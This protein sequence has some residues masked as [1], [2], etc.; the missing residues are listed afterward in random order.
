LCRLAVSSFAG[1]TAN[2][3]IDRRSQKLFSCLFL[4]NFRDFLKV[5]LA[6]MATTPAV[7]IARL[8]SPLFLLVAAALMAGLVA[9]VA[10][11]YLQQREATMKA[12]IDA[13]GKRSSTPRV[14][15]AV[16]IKDV[17]AG[18]VLN[19]NNFVARPVEADLVY[20]DSI[21]AADFAS[22][23]G[24]KLAR[25][26]LRGRPVRLTDLTAP[27]IR[28]V[29]SILPVGQRALTIDIDNINSIAQ[30]LRPNH[31][32]DVFLL[33]KTPRSAS[34]DN[35]EE[36][37]SAAEQATLYMQ[38]LVVL[39]TGT[40]FQDV[41][42]LD[43]AAAAKMARPGE[44]PGKER[45]YDTV[46]VLVSPKEAARLIVGQKM[47]SFR[48][49]LRG[50]EDRSPVRLAT[51]RGSDLLPG[52]QKQR[53]GGIEFIVGGKGNLI[54]QM[55]VAPSQD[56]GKAIRQAEQ[57]A[58]ANAGQG[59]ARAASQVAPAAAAAPA[60]NTMTLTVPMPTTRANSP[61]PSFS[62]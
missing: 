31:R 16:P 53:D 9:W 18:T 21:L 33:S 35:G 38:N 20:P 62:N 46:T 40:D 8:K 49:V 58:Q 22:M 51:L 32:I 15:V 11:Y 59:P 7:R 57:L 42:Q 17:A 30:T 2:S 61:V 28:D 36:D 25:P 26:V 3:R 50:T 24:M 5:K 47:G 54:S 41:N 48:V 56:I 6:K 12:E 14:E 29:A 23:E 60:P 45:T 4:R 10:Y 55:D 43:D 37:G 1:T 13:R 39:A 27:E 19:N 44:V 34:G 52:T